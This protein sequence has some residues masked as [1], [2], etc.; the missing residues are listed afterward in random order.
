MRRIPPSLVSG[1]RSHDP[2]LCSMA[3]ASRK[4]RTGPSRVVDGSG[5]ILTQD[6]LSRC[7][8]HTSKVHTRDTHSIQTPRERGCR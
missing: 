2:L 6:K 8:H 1:P 3:V 7:N 4:C 5:P